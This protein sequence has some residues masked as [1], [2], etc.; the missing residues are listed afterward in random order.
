[1]SMTTRS[2]A[3][4]VS[5]SSQPSLL[6]RGSGREGGAP[7]A[8]MSEGLGEGVSCCMAWMCCWRA[9]GRACSETRKGTGASI[10]LTARDVGQI[11]RNT[12]IHLN[13]WM[14][15]GTARTTA[16]P[17]AMLLDM[18]TIFCSSR[19]ALMSTSR[20]VTGRRENSTPYDHS[21]K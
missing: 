1:M 12:C 11:G 19:T 8:D 13:G 18:T 17:T 7:N 3:L 14:S 5:I 4:S 6:A 10:K 9:A 21:A 2:I 16:V 20:D 15:A